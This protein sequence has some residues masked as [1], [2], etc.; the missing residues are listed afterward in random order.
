M[1]AVYPEKEGP[2]RAPAARPPLP[3]IDGKLREALHQARGMGVAEGALNLISIFAAASLGARWEEGVD[4]RALV[5][6]A[7]FALGMVGQFWAFRRA[8]ELRDAAVR[9]IREL[10]EEGR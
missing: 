10:L 8:L 7:F 6:A 5:T 9:R 4:A 2:Y 1:P 3:Y